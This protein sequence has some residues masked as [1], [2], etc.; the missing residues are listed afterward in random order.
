M[1]SCHWGKGQLLW[2]RIKQLS[3]ST[4]LPASLVTSVLQSAWDRDQHFHWFGVFK[5]TLQFVRLKA[6]WQIFSCSSFQKSHLQPV[7]FQDVINSWLTIPGKIKK[8]WKLIFFYVV[9]PYFQYFCW[10]YWMMFLAPV[11]MGQSHDPSKSLCSLAALSK[12]SLGEVFQTSL[13]LCCSTTVGTFLFTCLAF[14][15]SQAQKMLGPHLPH[16]CLVG[17][18]LAAFCGLSQ[19]WEQKKRAWKGSRAST[20]LGQGSRKMLRRRK[21]EK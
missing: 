9:C 8:T 10:W 21:I 7:T 6:V 13:L 3:P 12:N 16:R 19:Q 5:R 4:P 17:G 11:L 14:E 18:E 20:S 2:G 15:H 1:I